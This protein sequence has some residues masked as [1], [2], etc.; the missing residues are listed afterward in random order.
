VKQQWG[1]L[2]DDHLD[3]ISGNRDELAGKLQEAYGVSRDEADRQIRTFE[4]RYGDWS[5]DETLH[6][7]P[8][9]PP[10]RQTARS[11]S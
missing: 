7:E 5:P 1:K 6:P 8:A 11:R 3:V 4:D 2:T 10:R 9:D